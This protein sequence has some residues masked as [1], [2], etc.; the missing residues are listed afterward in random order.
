M[1]NKNKLSIYLIK[2]EYKVFEELIKISDGFEILDE[3][4][5]IYFDCSTKRSPHWVTS[6]LRDKIDKDKIFVANARVVLLK[7]I[8]LR[9]FGVSRIFAVT[10]G[11]GK[12]MLEN[13]ILEE[14]FGIKVALNTI[15]SN[16]LRQIN[17]SNVGGSQKLSR[18]QLPV[19]SNIEDFGLDVDRDLV[20][21]IT[22]ISN[23]E[24]Y[25]KGTITGGDGVNLSAKV[26]I[27]NIDEF[28]IE[29]Y[30]RYMRDDYRKD[31]GW[32]DQIQKVK[33]SQEKKK[34][35][36]Y[37]INE[38]NNK[39]NQFWMAAPEVINWEGISGF[40]YS[41]GEV[42]DD[43]DIFDVCASFRNPLEDINQLK[44]KKIYA[45]SAI[46]EANRYTWSALRCMYGECT[47]D[48]ESYCISAGEWYKIETNFVK[49][50]NEAYE[51][52]EISE[53]SFIDRTEIHRTEN[54]YAK[55]FTGNNKEQFL[56][57]DKAIITH[58]GGRGKI[59]L[60]DIISRDKELIHLK[61]YSGSATLSHLFNQGLISTELFFSDSEF[62]KKA[63][64]KILEMGGGE[65]F[66]IAD[67]NDIQVVFGIISKGTDQLPK[68]PFF[69]KVSFN[70]VKKRLNA[71][72]VKVS[73]KNIR[74]IRE[75]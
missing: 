17:K 27:T 14:R 11:Y 63:N 56:L 10:M 34:L 29:T 32:I 19:K 49:R 9:D 20:N 16:G 68:I 71:F 43:I 75:K 53:I 50:M 73:V 48:E 39:S 15:E 70:H 21:Q 33:D 65:K 52:T 42:H 25:I 6:F 74:D 23:D 60:C 35:N 2:E 28:L 57:M 67:K 62:E 12:T 31:F 69:S 59:E 54:E 24:S 30:K 5:S 7:R 41:K 13:D 44:S 8:F 38:V 18:E 40:S 26:D 1:V 22:G 58:G 64:K 3:N 51:K 61:P 36:D 66:E 47:I 72:N 45:I 37:L 4:T 46:D 55:E